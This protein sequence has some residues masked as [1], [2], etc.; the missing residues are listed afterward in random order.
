MYGRTTSLHDVIGKLF[1]LL[2]ALSVGNIVVYVSS[3]AFYQ[4]LLP[5]HWMETKALQILGMLL[6]W[7]SMFWTIGA[8][9]Q[10]GPSWRI[11]ID[12]KTKT[13]LI[14]AGLFRVSRHPIYS[15]MIVTALGLFMVM[16]N[17]LS[18]LILAAT[19]ITIPIQA[20]LEE[21]HLARV[22]GDR[23]LTYLKRTRRW[24]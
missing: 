19:M 14:T 2:I 4:H 15:G 21:E 17:L 13:S 24:L 23:Y 5:F 3:P 6:A 22:H 1:A 18:L 11:G 9:H 12:T 7:A 16:P 10:M 20:R 8:Q